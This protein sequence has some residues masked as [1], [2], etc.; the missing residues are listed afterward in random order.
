[1][2]VQRGIAEERG[3]RKNEEEVEEA[4]VPNF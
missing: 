4:V 2:K 3:D 1:V